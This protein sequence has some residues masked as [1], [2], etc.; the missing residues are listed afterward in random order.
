MS[1]PLAQERRARIDWS[2]LGE[3]GDQRVAGWVRDK[4]HVGALAALRSD[5][6]PG[7]GG[8]RTRLDQLDAE[9]DL[10]NLTQLG[11]RVVIPGDAEWPAGLDDLD[12]PPHCLWLRGSGHLATLAARSVALVGARAATATGRLTAS[13]LAA[14][15]ARRG[16]TVFSGA[17]FGIDAAAHEGAL[18]AEAPTVAVLACGVDRA[19]PAAHDRLLA[20][21]ADGGVV[22][23]EA[24]LGYAALRH[25]FL[26]RNRLIAAMTR[27][28]V[29]V[30]AGIRS[31]SKNTAATADRLGRV[32]GA[33]PGPVTS[34][35]SAGCHQLIRSGM[36][37]LVTGADEV[38]DLVGEFGTDTV[39]ELSVATDLDALTTEQR[40][41]HDHL[42]VR[43]DATLGDLSEGTTYALTRVI[44]LV[45]QLEDLG[46]AM[47]TDRGWRR[48]SI[49]R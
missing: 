33:V 21:I 44:T 43:T 8:F 26:L 24:P 34:M 49:G 19:Y 40:V 3:P 15:M 20:A 41:V 37:V 17:A 27:G 36:A 31:G 30:E 39:E 11:G 42:R 13:E 9:R 23:S 25:R 47:R 28:T 6:L 38:A 16:F 48:S 1:D 22:V 5:T 4:G 35:V 2:R 10:R 7:A 12:A 32:V 18:A 45:G 46:F 14:G 29:V